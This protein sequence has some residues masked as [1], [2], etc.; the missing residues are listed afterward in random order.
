MKTETS[1]NICRRSALLLSAS[2]ATA[3]IASALTYKFRYQ[4]EEVRAYL[5]DS[6]APMGAEDERARGRTFREEQEAKFRKDQSRILERQQMQTRETIEGLRRKYNNQVMGKFHVWDLVEKLAFVYDPTDTDLPGVSQYLHVQQCL[7]VMD[8]EGADDDLLLIAMLHDLGKIY[9]LTEEGPENIVL[10]ANRLDG[11]GT[12]LANHLFQFGHGELIYSRIKDHVPD[13]IA[14]T[15]RY[16]TINAGKERSLM[17]Q[18]DLE[19]YE[20]YL[21]PFRRYDAEFKSPHFIPKVQ[22]NRFRDLVYDYF[23]KPILF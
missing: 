5:K 13:H 4:L 18:T 15:V 20:A 3:G 7:K 8:D 14:W 9:L 17:N 12:G 16:H 1:N 19:F 11:E 6:P 2:G 22:M 23:P 10:R 21:K